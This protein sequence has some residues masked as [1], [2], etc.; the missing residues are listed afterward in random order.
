MTADVTIGPLPADF[1]RWRELLDLILRSFAYMDGVI[2]PPSSAY[3]LTPDLLARKASRQACF[4]A[5]IGPKLA[6]CAFAEE[7]DNLVYLS[8]LAVDPDSQGS[9]IGRGLIA[10]VEAHALKAGK[11]MLELQ[12]RVE[13]DANHA[14]FRRLGFVEIGRTAHSGFDRPTSITFRKSLP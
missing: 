3:R 11:P 10:A 9:G 6:G 8:T 13:L 2:D 14:T 5:A 7:R 1:D 12:T 4:V